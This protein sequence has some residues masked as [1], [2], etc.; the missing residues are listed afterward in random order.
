M[1]VQIADAFVIEK[2]TI[3]GNRWQ[4]QVSKVKQWPQVENSQQAHDR[5]IVYSMKEPQPTVDRTGNPNVKSFFD[6]I[7]CFLCTPIDC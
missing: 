4:S 7:L 1:C 6:E 5:H 2:D 3:K